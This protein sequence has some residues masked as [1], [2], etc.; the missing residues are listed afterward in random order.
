MTPFCHKH[1][2]NLPT[3]RGRANT[4]QVRNVQ[5]DLKRRPLG[6][7]WE[8]NRSRMGRPHPVQARL[9]HVR[10]HRDPGAELSLLCGLATDRLPRPAAPWDPHLLFSVPTNRSLGRAVPSRN[11]PTPSVGLPGLRG[12][13][14][15]R[16]WVPRRQDGDEVLQ[17]APTSTGLF[18]RFRVGQKDVLHPSDEL[19]N[20]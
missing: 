4:A 2:R 6:N 7:S 16:E 20:Q 10:L 8:G 17:P 12:G 3:R 19:Q 9:P 14:L 5:G 11:R 13:C 1:R 18:S 15:D